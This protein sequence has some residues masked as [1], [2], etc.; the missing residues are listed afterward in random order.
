MLAEHIVYSTALAVIAGMFCLRYTGRDVSWIII[1]L[2]W[3][4]DTD[5]IFTIL[6]FFRLRFH[7]DG[8][9]LVHGTFHN[10]AAMFVFAV[11]FAFV[12]QRF[13][14]R[15]LDAFILSIIGFGAHLVE[16]ALVYPQGYALLWPFIR[17]NVGLGWLDPSATEE[18][19]L[20]NFFHIAN[21]HVLFIG[22]VF[23][24]LAIFIRTLFEGSDW[25]RYYMPE[26]LYKRYFAGDIVL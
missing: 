7:V 14:L 13:G 21:T 24:L 19:Y 3:A 15:Y 22:L 10:V 9:S 12:L 1:V 5:L 18:T 20:A 25:I 6:R 2:A 8:Y 23:L 16:D 26:K 4:P 17:E 11:I